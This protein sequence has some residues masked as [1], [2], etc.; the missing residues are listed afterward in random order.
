MESIKKP[1]RKDKRRNFSLPSGLL[2]YFI[3]VGMLSLMLPLSSAQDVKKKGIEVETPESFVSRKRSNYKAG[4]ERLEEHHRKICVGQGGGK[5]IPFIPV[6][7]PPEPLLEKVDY[8]VVNVEAQQ[9]YNAFG[10][11]P[12]NTN[13]WDA[14]TME[15][16]AKA[17]AQSLWP[18]KF[19]SGGVIGS[20]CNDVSLYSGGVVP[21]NIALHNI[22]GACYADLNTGA[23]DVDIIIGTGGIGWAAIFGQH[24][25]VTS[26]P[27]AGFNVV[28]L[29][30]AFDGVTTV[31][32]TIEVVGDPATQVIDYIYLQNVTP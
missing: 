15:V 2:W 5:I 26:D 9:I 23:A 1:E 29:F 17:F 32:L 14:I 7:G 30:E 4:L 11:R 13:P 12:G 6:E 22:D 31:H 28:K 24:G 21:F 20:G 18:E 27:S 3:V 16:L 8:E 10:L 25:W 19:G